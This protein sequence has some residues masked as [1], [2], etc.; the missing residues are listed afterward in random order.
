MNFRLAGDYR[1]AK[2]GTLNASYERENYD[3]EYR[4]RDRTWEDKYRIEYAHRGWE[5]ATLRTS[6]EYAQRRG[7]EYVSDPIRDFTSF[8]LGPTPTAGNVSSWIRVLGNLRR[9]D[10][11]DRDSSTLNA[12][13]NASPRADLDVGITAQ[14]KDLKY[15]GS[16]FG[17]MDH[18]ERGSLAFDATYQP[19]ATF[20]INGYYAYQTGKMKQGGIQN[21]AC[22]V[23]QNGVTAANFLTLCPA[24]GG[25]LYP[26]NRAWYVDSKDTNN[27]F[28]LSGRYDFGRA[29]FDLSY[30]YSHGRTEIGYD[31]GSGLDLTPAQ[32][33]LI[34]NGFSDITFTQ[35]IV[36][37]SLL[38]PINK[39]FA[40]RLFY[41]FENGKIRD[42]HYDGVAENPVPGTGSVYLDSGPQDYRTNVFGVFLRMML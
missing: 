13:F 32:I 7:S 25:P 31:Y 1:L 22:T 42:W 21:A 39:T 30:T 9:F 34:G 6:Y 29:L 5:S 35:N 33:A 41:R 19:S 3:R 8:S 37:S 38:V 4:E 10:L 20:S 2:G 28:G 15:P 16:E 27:V 36:E 12:N 18:E 17:R 11:A 24:A 14:W 23:G 26:L 40:V